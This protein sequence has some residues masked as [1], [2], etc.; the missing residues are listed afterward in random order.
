MPCDISQEDDLSW[1]H[2]PQAKN[3]TFQPR[4]RGRMLP[5]APRKPCF[6]KVTEGL[7]TL[8]VNPSGGWTWRQAS[9][10]LAV[11]KPIPHPSLAH[12][13]K[14]PRR[15]YSAHYKLCPGTPGTPAVSLVG[16]EHTGV[17]ES[18]AMGGCRLQRCLGV[19]SSSLGACPNLPAEAGQASQ[20][21]TDVGRKRGVVRMSWWEEHT[22][23][24]NS[25]CRVSETGKHLATIQGRAHDLEW[26]EDGVCVKGGAERLERLV[27]S[28]QWRHLTE[29]VYC[30]NWGSSIC[31][32]NAGDQLLSAY[33]IALFNSAPLRSF[34]GKCHLSLPWDL[35]LKQ[36]SRPDGHPKGLKAPARLHARLAQCQAWGVS[37][38]PWVRQS[39]WKSILPPTCSLHAQVNPTSIPRDHPHL[40]PLLVPSLSLGSHIW[41]SCIPKAL[42][43]P[44]PLIHFLILPYHMLL[45]NRTALSLSGAWENALL[46]VATSWCLEPWETLG[47]W[48]G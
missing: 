24:G 34:F 18:G 23:Q 11:I 37:T 30:S 4:G 1:F 3:T 5:S 7:V 45:S 38:C 26:L 13:F 47:L 29:P 42:W 46:W 36:C 35:H 15:P 39:C 8:D 44:H 16:E 40:W 31:Q 32:T 48:V 19:G 12:P 14:K 2:T 41:V 21:G 17:G 27:P 6:G 28:R 25:A 33:C 10:H 20:S 43:M 9:L 22:R